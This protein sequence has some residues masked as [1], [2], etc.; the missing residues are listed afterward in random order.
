[1]L[2]ILFHHVPSKHAPL[3]ASAYYQTLKFPE[4][5]DLVRFWHE[6]WNHADVDT[7]VAIVS[8]ADHPSFNNLPKELTAKAVR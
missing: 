6:T 5:Q 4:L 7:M 2:P 3:A 1:M 8:D